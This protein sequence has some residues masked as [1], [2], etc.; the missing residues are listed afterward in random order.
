MAGFGVGAAAVAEEL[1][2]KLAVYLEEIAA[3]VASPRR[4]FGTLGKDQVPETAGLYILCKEEP[5][6]VLYVGQAKTRAA[7]SVWGVSDGLRFR[8]MENHLAYRGDDNFVRYVEG[9]RTQVSCGCSRVRSAAVLGAVD[10]GSGFAKAHEPGAPHDCCAGAKVESGVSGPEKR[11]Q[12]KAFGVL[13]AQAVLA[14]CAFA[15]LKEELWPQPDPY[16]S[17]RRMT[18]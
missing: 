2:Q 18:R 8:I 13:S 4:S 3:L 9:I 10:G 1:R 17:H 7:R 14:W 15:R 12:R 16:H 5:F 6:E 11:S